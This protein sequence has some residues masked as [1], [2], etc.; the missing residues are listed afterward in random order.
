ML[1]PN[2]IESNL[3][4]AGCCLY[5]LTGNSTQNA[6]NGKFSDANTDFSVKNV[7]N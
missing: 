1:C 3:I 5:L 4:C 2:L 7:R 6:Y